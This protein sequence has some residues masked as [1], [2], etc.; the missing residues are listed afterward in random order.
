MSSAERRR[1]RRVKA[2]D[3]SGHVRVK[4]QVLAL[5][6]PID[7]I[8]MGGLFVRCSNPLP[9]GTPVVMELLQPK[10]PT[11][12]RLVGTTVVSIDAVQA[13][14]SGSIAGMG[15]RFDPLSQEN[16]ERLRR[17]LTVLVG[18]RIATPVSTPTHLSDEVQRSREA[19][20]FGFVSLS[21]SSEDDLH[22]AS[23][24]GDFLAPPAAKIADRSAAPERKLA[25]TPASAAARR[26]ST[27]ATTTNV[28]TTPPLTAPAHDIDRSAPPLPPPPLQISE[29]A[30]LMVQVRGLLLDLDETQA[31]LARRSREIEDLRAELQKSHAEAARNYARILE[32]EARLARGR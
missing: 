15:L 21:A 25:T 10:L 30:K 19:F 6:L 31:E 17:L 28:A 13:L 4:D 12:L 23:S 3:V 18:D 7:N 14:A 1:H 29:S 32:L 11:P 2:K 8:S 22:A 27:A 26:P 9:I 5:G 24:A 16:S 20:D